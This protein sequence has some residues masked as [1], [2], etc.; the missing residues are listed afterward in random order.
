ML[1]TDDRPIEHYATK[2]EHTVSTFPSHARI[3]LLDKSN[4]LIE[5][6]KQQASEHQN[7]QDELNQ[8]AEELEA[9]KAERDLY[10][11]SHPV[12]AIHQIEQATMALEV[13]SAQIGSPAISKL[14]KLLRTII[15]SRTIEAEKMATEAKEVAGAAS[16]MARDAI[17]QVESL[18]K[19]FNYLDER[20]YSDSLCMFHFMIGVCIDIVDMFTITDNVCFLQQNVTAVKPAFLRIAVDVVRHILAQEAGF[21]SWAAF[22]REEPNSRRWSEVLHNRL[23]GLNTADRNFAKANLVRDLLESINDTNEARAEILNSETI[24]TGL[25][26]GTEQMVAAGLGIDL[27]QT[28]MD[29]VVPE[30]QKLLFVKRVELPESTRQTIITCVKV[31]QSAKKAAQ[32]IADVDMAGAV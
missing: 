15:D 14:V 31:L 22:V 23:N 27:N 3:V 12:D 16:T 20:Q 18:T 5:A 32:T 30:L 11:Q 6:L 7:I 8:A 4:V 29:R 24:V 10:V 19:A 17:G 1:I 25:G 2:P 28:D 21:T 26:I 9:V 13:P